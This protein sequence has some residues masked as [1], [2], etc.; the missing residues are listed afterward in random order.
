MEKMEKV[1]TNQK[2]HLLQVGSIDVFA[3]FNKNRKRRI[4]RERLKLFN[5]NSLQLTFG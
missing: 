5:W 4:P 2:L 1:I 3:K